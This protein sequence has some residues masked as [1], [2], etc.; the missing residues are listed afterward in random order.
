MSQEFAEKLVQLRTR[1]DYQ[2]FF[3][4][5]ICMAMTLALLISDDMT[6]ISI[7]E[8]QMEDR[9]TSLQQVLPV[10][11][12]D[13]NPL[14]SPININDQVMGP[15]EVYPA[16]KQN[17]FTGAA[18][19]IKAMGYGGTITLMMG[20]NSKGETLGVRVISHKE[21][22]GLADKI[23]IG[24]S[25]WIT[26]FDGMSIENTPKND[27]AVKK[28]GGKIDQFTGATI[29]PRAVVKSV[30]SGLEFFARHKAEIETSH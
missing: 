18:F 11:L 28:D 17:A 22:P 9:L 30:R 14:T 26:V 15:I 13:N 10:T 6:R 27:W 5:L 12:Y 7:A 4:G 3:L 1:V 23:E 19:Q 2:G 20:V 25:P 16:K 21:T 29:T 8:R 24:R